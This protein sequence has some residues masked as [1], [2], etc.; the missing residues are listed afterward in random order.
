MAHDLDDIRYKSYQ[1][2]SMR[3]QALSNIKDQLPV[4]FLNQK[5]EQLI[6]T[7]DRTPANYK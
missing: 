4:P 7:L 2:K 1:I 3:K 5:M 6:C